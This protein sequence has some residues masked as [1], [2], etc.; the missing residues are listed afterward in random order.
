MNTDPTL[1]TGNDSKEMELRELL[2][3]VL[4]RK[5]LILTL[6]SLFLVAGVAYVLLAAPVYQ[7]DAMIQVESKTSNIPGLA[8]LQNSLPGAEPSASQATTEIALITSRAVVGSAVDELDLDTT[9]RPLRVP[10]VGGFLARRFPDLAPP[11]GLTRYAWGAES[12]D[13]M[14]LVVPP[15]LLGVPL[16]LQAGQTAGSYRLLDDDGRLLLEGVAGAEAEGGGV[17][18]LV[19]ALKAHPGARFEIARLNR[20]SVVTMLQGQISVAERGKDSGIL[21]LS[22]QNTD[23]QRAQ[24]F[25]QHISEAYVRQNVERNSAE[26]S[27]QLAFVREQLP[28][29][30]R[31]VEAA[32][33]A[34]NTY[35][36]R[37]NAVDITMQTQGLLEQ[38]VSVEGNIQKLRLQQ[39]E[40]DRSFTREHP[41]Y[42]ALMRQIGELESRK[43]QF[44]NQVSKLPDTQQV[45]LR[46]SRDLQVSN[47]LY[48]SLLNQAQ[49]LDV[50]RAGT[51]GNVRIVDAAVADPTRPVKPKKKL[52]VLAS[53]LVGGFLSVGFVLL[54]RMLHGV[55]EDPAQIENLGLPVYAVIPRSEAAPA[56]PGRH[57]EPGLPPLLALRAPEDLAVEAIRSLRTSLHFAL[58]ETRNNILMISGPRPGVGKT[59]VSAN[60]A[61]VVAQAGQRVLLIDADMRKG[62]LHKMLGARPGNGLSDVLS[63]RIAFAHAVHALAGLEKVHF[64]T[65]GSIPPN[66]SELLMHHNFEALLEQVAP[67]YDLVIIDTPPI[68]AVTDAA[69]VAQYAGSNLLVAR[70]AVNQP[71]EIQLTRKRFEQN[72]TQVKGAIFNAVEPRAGGYY[73]YGYYE[74]KPTA[75]E[76]AT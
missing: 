75:A 6:T 7:A 28:G 74:Y 68:L 39:A 22:Y 26:A 65:R 5:W 3:A 16:V 46:L 19:A 20:L 66:P 25:L 37:A 44:Q 10:V 21:E 69:I 1:A 9:A 50:A 64:L 70:F 45:L 18:L 76:R 13:V 32:Q 58:L 61:A 29:V 14:R 8:E 63:G 27:S 30:R 55:I 54:Q 38:E 24:A 51:V 72:G 2:S 53:V 60:L 56:L 49:Q 11:P 23:P 33:Q 59:F 47:E 17:R 48:T 36:T 73:S 31:Q 12:V 52:V 34:M 62:A 15:H 42:R 67:N 57:R 43:A 4:D 71:R 35:Q 41:A 40:M